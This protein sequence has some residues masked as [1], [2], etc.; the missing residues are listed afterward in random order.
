[1]SGRVSRSP[2]RNKDV[3]DL[4]RTLRGEHFRRTLNTQRAPRPRAAA[5]TASGLVGRS[6]PYAEIY[7]A[8]PIPRSWA[9]ATAA[10]VT[11]KTLEGPAWRAT[12]LSLFFAQSSD[13]PNSVGTLPRSADSSISSTNS[14]GF[15]HAVSV[16]PCLAEL[17][18][19]VLLTH[20]GTDA[21]ILADLVP[22]LPPHH[23]KRFM[24]I[25]AVHSPLSNV[26]LRVL[27]LP[28]TMTMTGARG[29]Y[30]QVDGELV[31]VEPANPPRPELFLVA[32]DRSEGEGRRWDAEVG[33]DGDGSDAHWQP[34]TALAIVSTLL[35]IPTLLAF[36][37][38]L[39][40]LALIRLSAPVPL[41]RLPDK[42]PLLECLDISYN[43][44]LGEPAWGGER[45]LERVAWNR[46][47]Y[48]KVLGCQLRKV[49]ERRWDDVTIIT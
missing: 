21:D 4:L 19:R 20:Y 29:Q 16:V 33:D 37:P 6:L 2:K 1:M 40:R 35:P 7:A 46:W 44:W 31:I 22:Y 11:D 26:S 36:P 25:C 30:D 18:L 39:T 47:E 17:C 45:A 3:N 13:D 9:A 8:G 32:D 10:P 24:R 41:H 14:T 23:R 28:T 27:L 38:S 12:A 5:F 49:N 15:T 43:W 34:L 48:L 42:C